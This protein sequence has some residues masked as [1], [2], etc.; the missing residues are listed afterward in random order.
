MNR[1]AGERLTPDATV[2]GADN[3]LWSPRIPRKPKLYVK[4]VCDGVEQRSPTVNSGGAPR[5]HHSFYLFV[6]TTNYLPLPDFSAYSTTK[7]TTLRL[8]IRH[9]GLPFLRKSLGWVDTTI[10]DLHLDLGKSA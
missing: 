4:L 6:P 3:L 2:S 7:A 1:Q 8:E 9:D 10:S 5:W